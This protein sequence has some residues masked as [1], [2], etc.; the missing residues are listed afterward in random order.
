MVHSTKAE[1]ELR[2]EH[3]IAKNS[4]LNE[5]FLTATTMKTS[6]TEG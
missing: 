6:K 3:R 1:N 5:Q 2:Y 4:S